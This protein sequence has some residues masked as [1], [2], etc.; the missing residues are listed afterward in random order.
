MLAA[1]S[2][3]FGAVA[4]LPVHGKPDARPIR[5]LVRARKGARGGPATGPALILN[6]AAGRPTA[7]CG[8]I[9]T[10]LG[11]AANDGR[12]Y[13]D[14]DNNNFSPRIAAAW[15]PRFEGGLLGKLFGD[16]KMSIRGGYSLVYDR[17]GMALVNTFDQVGAFGQFH[18]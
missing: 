13:F 16:A 3:D 9:E 7:D 14:R 11:G 18:P 6:D 4:I 2:K 12:P 10:Q 1:L 17:L 15:A 8:L 5:V